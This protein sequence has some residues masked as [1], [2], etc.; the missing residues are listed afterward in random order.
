M[1]TL[2]SFSLIFFLVSCIGFSFAQTAINTN[3]PNNNGNGLVLFHI[4]ND[5]AFPVVI[6]EFRCHLGT[7]TTN[8]VSLLYCVTPKVDSATPWN[9]GVVGAGQ[10]DWI[11]VASGTINSNTAN[12]IVPVFTAMT[13]TIPAN[14]TYGFAFS[15]TTL[16]Y[17]SL[18]NGAG[19]NTFSNGSVSI[20]TGDG[21][22]WG[23]VAAPAT[24]GNYPR[25]LIGGITWYGISVLK[26]DLGTFAAKNDGTKNKLSWN[27]LSEIGSD[28]YEIERSI[29]GKNFTK[30]ASIT[31]K[32]AASNYVFYDENPS[33]GLNYYRLK[34]KE[35]NGD[36]QYSHLSYANVKNLTEFNV[37]VYPNPVTDRI[38]G[39]V[40]GTSSKGG[41]I[42]LLD[43]NRKLLKET[44]VSN[45]EF[46]LFTKELPAGLY[47]LNYVDELN[48][49][50][51]HKLIKK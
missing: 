36:F 17:S 10:N 22:S 12:G 51:S 46:T 41:S 19:I 39:K 34:L 4:K 6:R 35:A 9:L 26:I 32:G 3:H 42:K 25:G 38:F 33:L 48:N 47:I 11:E 49:S 14:T 15:A 13:L 18:T 37:T 2:I 30:I 23:G 29:D 44:S 16:Q 21:I 20:L 28:I 43:V 27:S 31:A 8:N 50:Y 45:S 5:N 1:K 40:N 24:P 7:A